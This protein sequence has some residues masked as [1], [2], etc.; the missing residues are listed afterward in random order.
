MNLTAL[1]VLLGFVAGNLDPGYYFTLPDQ[2]GTIFAVRGAA[3]YLPHFWG[4]EPTS[5]LAPELVPVY[6]GCA[7]ISQDYRHTLS[8]GAYQEYKLANLNPSSELML[9]SYNST[10][11]ACLKATSE[12][13]RTYC[14]TSESQRV[15][16]CL[17]ANL[18]S[19]VLQRCV[20]TLPLVWFTV[21]M[22]VLV[23]ALA[24][25]ELYKRWYQRRH[26]KEQ[27]SHYPLP[28]SEAC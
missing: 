9:L 26:K 25:I 27:V 23:A 2:P 10:L 24:A 12:L 5:E 11:Q 13:Q 17:Q 3:S 28:K 7:A 1:I 15:I 6:Q 22:G 4:C 16:S 18:P 19:V 21:L 14:L 8:P 20:P